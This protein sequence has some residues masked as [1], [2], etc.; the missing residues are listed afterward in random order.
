MPTEI[1]VKPIDTKETMGTSKNASQTEQLSDMPT[2][3]GYTVA[4]DPQESRSSISCNLCHW[5]I[6]IR[7]L[8]AE[9]ESKSRGLIH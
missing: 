9:I 6:E 5:K 1:R 4:S 7:G 8:L 2:V 3:T